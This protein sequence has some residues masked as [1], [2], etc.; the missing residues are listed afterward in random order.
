MHKW[1]SIIVPVYNAE[2]Y[3]NVCIESLVH[4][5]SPLEEFEIILFDDG[6]H[7]SS[8]KIMQDYAKEYSNI[9]VFS[10]SNVGV[11]QTRNSAIELAEGEYIWFVDSD[12]MIAENVLS[13]LYKE[14]KKKKL[15]ILLFNYK[16]IY[17]YVDITI[18]SSIQYESGEVK[19]GQ[20]FILSNHHSFYIWDRLF[21]RA[22]L[23]KY[24]LN[25]LSNIL[26]EDREFNIRC[27]YYA[28]AV[29]FISLQA[30]YYYQ[31][32]DSLSHSSKYLKKIVE[33]L[34]ISMSEH[35]IFMRKNPA[36]VFWVRVLLDNIRKLHYFLF[37]LRDK[38]M[39]Y[40]ILS[41]ERIVLNNS[42]RHLPFMLNFEYIIL[43]GVTLNPL[44][45]YNCT[46][47][48]RK[49]KIFISKYK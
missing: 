42:L 8:L 49:C 15:D 33:S 48:I 6:S 9:R 14:L 39:K 24:K 18:N 10:H 20:D 1:L 35:E 11:S 30:Y 21:N 26:S 5:D 17:H 46:I 41:E 37:L 16:K 43:R 23:K 22:F 28:K 12:D 40:K 34:L 29:R 38:R 32:D 2:W 19:K 13:L 25:F 4:Q 27:Y 44:L 3:L 45:I 47:L 31:R 7:D 36:S